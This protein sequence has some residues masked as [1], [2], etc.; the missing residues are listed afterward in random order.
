MKTRMIL[1][2]G[3]SALI[4]G[5]TMV[6]CAA[7]GGSGVASA[8]DRS[9]KATG[10]LA[11]RNA[12]DA[13]KALGK[14]DADGAIRFSET[15]VGLSPR[16]AEYRMALGQSYLQA[17]RFD[18]A[19]TAFA[20]VLSLAPGNGK[21]A[22]NLALSQIATGDWAGARAT[23]DANARAIPASD[24]GLA[25][26][27]AGDPQRGVALLMAA[28]R[29]PGADAKV[30]QN[31]GLSLALA[32]QWGPARLAAAA[33]MSP[34]DVDARMRQWAQ[35]AAPAHAADQVASLLGITPTADGG[36]PVSL[37]L[38]APVAMSAA[39]V[40]AGPT[41][42][43]LPAVLAAVV[44]VAVVPVV[45]S[46]AVVASSAPMAPALAKVVFGPS[47]EIVQTVPVTLIRN[48]VRANKIA[49]TA[50]PSARSHSAVAFS[51]PA[52]GGFY[53]QLGAYQ[54]AAVARDGW[55][56]AT[57]RFSALANHQPT[58]MTFAN[59]GTSFYRLSVG[60]FSRG[61]ADRM[62]RSYRAHGGACFVRKDGGDRTAQWLD[63]RVQVASR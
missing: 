35:L 1:S 61:D 6:G 26:A 46:P 36:Q 12:A 62:C 59:A 16:N 22:L 11:A 42:V 37:A 31:L 54:N 50:A 52:A 48:D 43:A 40:V 15:A 25:V 57:R 27:L 28:A 53:V 32:G 20:D 58:G 38:N 51:A 23:L 29:A 44:P 4:F 8:S 14:H 47:R 45:V 13:V 56:R 30:R 9:D 24:L 60:G 33:D 49:V 17:G 5:G 2:L 39:M 10:K 34:A 19:R 41:P 21:A 63:K 7:T 55:N 3:F 18:S